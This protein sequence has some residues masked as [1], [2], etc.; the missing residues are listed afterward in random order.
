M[1][2]DGTGFE[3]RRPGRRGQAP[4]DN[5]VSVMIVAVAVVLLVTPISVAALVDVVRSL[6]GH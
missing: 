3:P 4:S 1:P 6:R 2:F 5:A